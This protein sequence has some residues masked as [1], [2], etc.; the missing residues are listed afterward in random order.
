[1][2]FTI[3]ALEII[4]NIEWSNSTKLKIEDS[5]TTET[6]KANKTGTIYLD[7]FLKQM[8]RAKRFER[9]P[10]FSD[11]MGKLITRLSRINGGRLTKKHNSGNKLTIILN[12][13]NEI[14][15][16][17]TLLND[18]ETQPSWSKS[19]NILIGLN[20]TSYN[21]HSKRLTKIQSAMPNLE[22]VLV[23]TDSMTVSFTKSTFNRIYNRKDNTL[24]KNLLFLASKS[25]TKYVMLTRRLR[26]IHHEFN[27]KDFVDPLMKGS[28][29]VISGS[30]LYPDGHWSSGCY[31]SKLIWSQYKVQFGFDVMYQQQKVLCDYVDGPF[32][33]DRDVLLGYLE[34]RKDCP[35]ELVYPDIIYNMAKQLKIMK[36]HLSSLFYMEKWCDF[37]NLTRNNWLDFA[38]KNDI[39][40]FHRGTYNK[41]FEFTYIESKVKCE[42]FMAKTKTMFE[43]RACMRDLHKMMINTSK[44][45]DKLGYQYSIYAGS[46]LGALKLQDSLPWD[47]DEDFLFR[48]QNFTSLVKHESE[49]KK[50][51]MSFSKGQCEACPRTI[52]DTNRWSCGYIRIYKGKWNI[53]VWGFYI[54]PSD[55]YKNPRGIFKTMQKVKKKSFP[56]SRIKG[57]VNT[58]LYI[59]GHWQPNRPN[60][61]LYARSRY[62]LDV[63]KHVQHW[64]QQGL[65]TSW[66]LY[67]TK[68]K[69]E[70]CTKEG[71]HLCMDQYLADGS[72]QFQQ[73]WA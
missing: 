4:S 44:L 31:Q 12:T 8:S 52:S 41:R 16:I 39:S 72:I 26:K 69:F 24:A 10:E 71:H 11:V 30:V 37:E 2:I 38:I 63:L 67:H 59:G 6:Q 33:M 36:S 20:E 19:A 28:S 25:S 18:I 5:V 48:S 9:N 66:L 29:D 58:K 56:T 50:L 32:A 42:K 1:M 60:P 23:K 62:G 35:D 49:W 61:G 70:A 13:V 65:K 46:G 15:N 45:F 3:T 55:M 17:E 14:S 21:K 57:G 73:P 47:I 7:L 27:I 40:E 54:F 43:Q 34:A 68:P 64:R 51:G 22:W 53:E